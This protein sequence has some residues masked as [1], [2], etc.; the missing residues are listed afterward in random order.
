MLVRVPHARLARQGLTRRQRW[1]NLAD[2]V[3]LSKEATPTR[4]ELRYR[5]GAGVEEELREL[6]E[7][8]SECCSSQGGQ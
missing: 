7:R 5:A 1:L 8:E 2:V 4:V 3:L 6:A